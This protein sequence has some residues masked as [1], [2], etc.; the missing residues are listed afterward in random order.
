LLEWAI[1]T[2]PLTTVE[3][4]KWQHLALWFY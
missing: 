3:G 4:A 2:L 1:Y